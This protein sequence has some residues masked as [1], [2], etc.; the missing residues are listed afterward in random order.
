MVHGIPIKPRLP[1]LSLFLP[2]LTFILEFS[3]PS[4]KTVRVVNSNCRPSLLGA[5]DQFPY[6]KG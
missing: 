6:L 2:I 3:I 1:I 4:S 5:R